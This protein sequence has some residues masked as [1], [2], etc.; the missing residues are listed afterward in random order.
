MVPLR[1][2]AVRRYENGPVL[3]WCSDPCTAMRNGCSLFTPLPNKHHVEIKGFISS[4][5]SVLKGWATNQKFTELIEALNPFCSRGITLTAPELRLRLTSCNEWQKEFH[6]SFYV[7]VMTKA[8]S[9]LLSAGSY[10]SS[11]LVRIPGISGKV[12]KAVSLEEYL[13]R[14]LFG[15]EAAASHQKLEFRNTL[16]YI[17][18]TW[19]THK[20]QNHLKPHDLLPQ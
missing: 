13:T 8:S 17:S 18:A 19:F 2:T 4:R 6:R 1:L 20:P 12:K 9:F 7:D 5:G 16:S 11:D 15:A 10:L 3:L 14:Y